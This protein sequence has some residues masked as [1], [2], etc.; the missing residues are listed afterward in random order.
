MRAPTTIIGASEVS[1]GPRRTGAVAGTVV[2][3]AICPAFNADGGRGPPREGRASPNRA[4]VSACARTAHHQGMS[5]APERPPVLPRLEVLDI[6]PP[7]P[8]PAPRISFVVP[9]FNERR[10]IGEVLDRVDAL[11]VEAQVI[12]VDDGSWDGTSELLD[13]WAAAGEGRHVVHQPNRGKGAAIRAAIP[14]VDGEIVVVQDADGEYD[15]AD[16]PILV[17]PIVRGVADVVYGSPPSR[18]P[19]ITGEASPARPGIYGLPL[20]NSGGT[21]PGGRRTP[22]PDGRRRSGRSSPFAF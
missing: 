9:V 19:P 4:G 11:G 8:A 17:E 21:Y 20:P 22:W 15:P 1:S 2:V 10:T 14:L 6:A 5:A 7:S 16:V 13:R 3:P 18:G 12:A